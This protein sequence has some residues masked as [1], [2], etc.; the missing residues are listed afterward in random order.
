MSRIGKEPITI[1]AGVE[2]RIGEDSVTV[3]GPRGSLSLRCS[4]ASQ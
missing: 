4:K 1:P 3:K 2:V